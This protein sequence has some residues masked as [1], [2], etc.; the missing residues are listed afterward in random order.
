MSEPKTDLRTSSAIQSC[1][2]CCCPFMGFVCLFVFVV[3][4]LRQ[5]LILLPMAAA[6]LLQPPKC[7]VSL[8]SQWQFHCINLPRANH[9]PCW[10]CLCSIFVCLLLFV[11][12]LLCGRRH[13]E[14]TSTYLRLQVPMEVRAVG[15]QAVMGSV[16]EIKY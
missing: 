8:C 3:V 4:F 2:F 14:A 9:Y 10:F 1:L 16:S 7:W 13:A 5:G 11:L 15:S 6:I 12:F